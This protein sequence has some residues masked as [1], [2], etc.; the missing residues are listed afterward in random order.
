M[1]GMSLVE[2]RQV[3]NITRV[4]PRQIANQFFN[5]HLKDKTGV[6][7]C[8]QLKLVNNLSERPQDPEI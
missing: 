4:K 3:T 8:G 5:V 1:M 7:T 6:L 2:I